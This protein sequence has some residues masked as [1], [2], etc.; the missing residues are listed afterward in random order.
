[1]GAK[2][3]PCRTSLRLPSSSAHCPCL[4]HFQSSLILLLVSA[5]K[6]CIQTF[7]FRRRSSSAKQTLQRQR[8]RKGWVP[9][10]IRW[11]NLVIAILLCWSFIA[12]LHYFL[13]KSQTD[14]GIIFA[15]DVNKIALNRSFWYLYLP[16]IVAVVFSIF[17]VWI[18]HDAKRFE[19]YRQMSKP[20]G[21]L[22]KDSMLLQYP[23][24]FMPAVPFTAFKRR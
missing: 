2:V 15:A 13:R 11:W 7:M 22:G 16:T 19:P 6:I 10:A 23:F 20:N 4:F 8:Q 9:P 1:V 5:S 14:G 24:D 21:A 17:V 18:D 3:E 12:V